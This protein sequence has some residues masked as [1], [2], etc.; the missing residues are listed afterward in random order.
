MK[1]VIEV[2]NEK[3]RRAT[4]F[5]M[6]DKFFLI[7]THPNIS[8]SKNKSNFEIKVLSGGMNLIKSVSFGTK[9]K[10]GSRK[11]LSSASNELRC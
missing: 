6:T 1:Y 4:N 5:W 9:Y 11:I 7:I 10:H 3:L 2:R 8:L